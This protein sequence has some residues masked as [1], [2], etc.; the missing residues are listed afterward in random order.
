MPLSIARDIP[1]DTASMFPII[2]DRK[3]DALRLSLSMK[4]DLSL[5]ACI[6]IIS[7]M[8]RFL[9]LRIILLAVRTAQSLRRW[10]FHFPLMY[11]GMTCVRESDS[12]SRPT[13]SPRSL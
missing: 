4:S 6:S 5:P 1:L 3:R 13:A 11:P 8:C 10:N 9:L 7:S 2:R 12:M